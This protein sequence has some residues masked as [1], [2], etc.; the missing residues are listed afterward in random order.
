MLNYIENPKE[1]FFFKEHDHYLLDESPKQE[2]ANYVCEM[3]LL[4]RKDK[5]FIEHMNFYDFKN[6]SSE[7]IRNAIRLIKN[8][9][10]QPYVKWYVQENDTSKIN[11]I[12][13]LKQAGY[14]DLWCAEPIK[15]HFTSV[16]IDKMI[17][18]RK[19]ENYNDLDH[20]KIYWMVKNY[21]Y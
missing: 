10:K 9:L 14:S 16:Q 15:N 1:C 12:I 11:T 17:Q 13:K 19:N 5:D 7:R 8:G 21:H 4:F 20:E 2:I 18:L 3:M 6:L